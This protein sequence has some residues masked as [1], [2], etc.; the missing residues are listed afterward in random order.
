M[1]KEMIYGEDARKKL[2]EGVR[3]LSLAVS[4]TLG[5]RGRNVII[6]RNFGSPL[7]TK[8]GVTVAKEIDLED[9]YENMGAQLIKEAATR[10]NTQAGDGTTT[11]TV[12]AY[13]IA[14]EG[15]KM[16]ATGYDPISIKRGIDEGVRIAIASL[17]DIKQDIKTKDDILNIASISANGDMEVGKQI[18]DAMDHVGNDGVVTVEESRTMETH[19]EYVEGMQV[20]RGYITPYF[21]TDEHMNCILEAPYI[22]VTNK[23]ISNI[24]TI[25]PLLEMVRR[26]DKPLLIIAD[27]VEGNAIQALIINHMKGV[28]R[29]CA[30]P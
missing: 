14:K 28:L 16:V 4:T 25:A 24:Q 3:K 23:T 7:I 22:L 19:V 15:V 21:A 17:D 11:A 13:A 8:D 29:S 20:E 26:A 2:F 5:P 12:L 27:G 9:P 6:N 30:I 18:A 10:T 1:S